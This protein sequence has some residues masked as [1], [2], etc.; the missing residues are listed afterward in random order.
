MKRKN[1]VI[2]FTVLLAVAMLSSLAWAQRHGR[3]MMRG[4]NYAGSQYSGG[5][6]GPYA[7]L[8]QEQVEAMQD[9]SDK[10]REDIVELQNKMIQKSAELRTI[11]A[12]QQVDTSKAVSVFKEIQDIRAE[13]FE[14][15]LKMSNDLQEKGLA[16]YGMGPGMMP[17]YG[18]M[19]GGCGMGMGPG[20]GYGPG[21]MCGYQGMGPGM[22]PGY[23]MMNGGCGMGMGPGYGYGPGM[24]RGGW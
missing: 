8:S 18:M 2:A 12:N 5:N 4:Q 11:L 23:G 21:M 9:I 10:Y 17:G 7:G 22:M 1:L 3:G 14:N 24:M 6:Y 15:R 19:N 20:C 16:P 13:M